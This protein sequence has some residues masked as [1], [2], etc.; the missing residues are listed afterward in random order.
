MIYQ[1]LSDYLLNERSS[2]LLSRL[3]GESEQRLIQREL[4]MK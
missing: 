4:G 3:K 2:K 1:Y